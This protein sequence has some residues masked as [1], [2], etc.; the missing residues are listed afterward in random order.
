MFTESALDVLKRLIVI[1]FKTESERRFRIGRANQSPAISK[2]D[3]EAIDAV[4]DGAFGS[5]VALQN[6]EV[7]R[8]PLET[9]V[10]ELKTVK[11]ESI[12]SAL[13][14][15]LSSI[16]MALL[17]WYGGGLALEGFPPDEPI[18]SV[19]FRSAELQK[20]LPENRWQYRLLGTAEGPDEAGWMIV[21]IDGKALWRRL[22]L[23]SFVV[24][25]AGE[26]GW[27]VDRVWSR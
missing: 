6:A 16:T 18:D 5:M 7:V 9:A 21:A 1:C 20:R 17:L 4:H 22:G 10:A 26:G 15:M 11:W 27:S 19:Y 13:T 24:L 12:L 2:V 8:V 25:E 3:P 14:D 23:P